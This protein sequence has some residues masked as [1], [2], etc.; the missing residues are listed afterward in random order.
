MTINFN[1]LY[2][3]FKSTP[4]AIIP[5][6]YKCFNI[7]GSDIEGKLN[8]KSNIL[9]LLRGTFSKTLN[10][11]MKLD[12]DSQVSLNTETIKINN[13]LSLLDHNLEDDIA[14]TKGIV[15]VMQ[16]DRLTNAIL[17]FES[18]LKEYCQINNIQSSYAAL[19]DPILSVYDI[20]ALRYFSINGL[21]SVIKHHNEMILT[22]HSKYMRANIESEESAALIKL[23]QDEIEKLYCITRSK[24]DEQERNERSFIVQN[25]EIDNVISRFFRTAFPISPMSNKS[26]LLFSLE[27]RSSSRD[28]SNQRANTDSP[29]P[30][31]ISPSTPLTS[32]SRSTP[33]PKIG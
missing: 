12:L 1:D 8:I 14:V 16:F 7:E 18:L 13:L 25:F 17:S 31:P 30:A 2:D 28:D 15:V 21:K 20:N 9:S 33:S 19:K 32:S 27:A 11:G 3:E 6:L 22:F 29:L 4:G 23:K 5:Y 10:I 26:P 24:L